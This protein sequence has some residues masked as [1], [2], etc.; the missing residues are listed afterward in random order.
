[1]P[2]ARTSSIQAITGSVSNANWVRITASSPC[3]MS[4]SRLVLEGAPQHLVGDV[5]V[6]LGVAGDRHLRTPYFCSRPVRITS[7]ESGYGPSGS[8]GSPPTTKTCS[9][10]PTSC[11]R[12][13]NSSSW[14]CD[15]R[16]RAEM[17]GTGTKPSSFTAFAAATRISR[18]SLPRNV[19]LIFVPAG[20]RVLRLLR[21]RGRPCPVISSEKPF[22]SWRAACGLAVACVVF[23]TDRGPFR[24]QRTRIVALSGPVYLYSIGNVYRYMASPWRSANRV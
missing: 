7:N 23:D 9:V 2:R 14:P 22:S 15:V 1:M 3:C 17:C 19:T 18:S 21:G 12:P 20:M 8:A 16:R 6:A 24:F 4:D 5:G 13:R 10:A 11:S